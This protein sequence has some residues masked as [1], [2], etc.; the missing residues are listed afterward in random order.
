MGAFGAWFDRLDTALLVA[1]DQGV[2][3]APGHL[4]LACRFS[5][6][7]ALLDDRQHD[8]T[9]PGHAPS[10]NLGGYERCLDSSDVNDVMNQHTLSST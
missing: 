8:D 10:W 5:F 3:P 9:F 1:L 7:Q 6:G 4:E 2:D